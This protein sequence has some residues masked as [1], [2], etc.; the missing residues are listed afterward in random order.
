[1]YFVGLLSL[2]FEDASDSSSDVLAYGWV[3]YGLYHENLHEIFAKF[4]MKVILLYFS[5]S[6]K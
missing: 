5:I 1:M 3:D 4:W 6:Q 2:D